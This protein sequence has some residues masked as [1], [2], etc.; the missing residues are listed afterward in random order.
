VGAVVAAEAQS[1]RKSK[2]RKRRERNQRNQNPKHDPGWN[3]T[4]CSKILI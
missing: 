2:K 4:I 3:Y 1:R